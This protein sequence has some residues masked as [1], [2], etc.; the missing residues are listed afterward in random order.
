MAIFMT[1]DKDKVKNVTMRIAW[2]QRQLSALVE[3]DLGA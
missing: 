1:A 3:V 2:G